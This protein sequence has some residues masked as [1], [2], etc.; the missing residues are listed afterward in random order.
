MD[1]NAAREKILVDVLFMETSRWDRFKKFTWIAVNAWNQTTGIEEKC[2]LRFDADNIRCQSRFFLR[3]QAISRPGREAFPSRSRMSGG[4]YG[5]SRLQGE[6]HLQ[7][8]GI[9]E[10]NRHADQMIA[11]QK[12]SFVTGWNMGGE[13]W[14]GSFCE[15]VS[16][17][18]L[19][20]GRSSVQ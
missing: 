4:A 12:V 10:S 5:C 7:E 3:C 1:R 6:K 19:F 20:P 11:C 9:R 18:R 13:D 15:S 14:P 2:Q 16:E 17:G 8:S